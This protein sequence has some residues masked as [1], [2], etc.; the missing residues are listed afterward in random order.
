[1]IAALIAMLTHCALIMTMIIVDSDV[2]TLNDFVNY[3]INCS[4]NQI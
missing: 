1:M 4:N 2:N 3:F